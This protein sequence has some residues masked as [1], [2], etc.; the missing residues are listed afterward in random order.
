MRKRFNRVKT[1]DPK[2]Y[3]RGV[4]DTGNKIAGL[5]KLLKKLEKEEKK[6]EGK[7]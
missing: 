1:C 2:F 6:D 4:V 3:G 5:D 7:S